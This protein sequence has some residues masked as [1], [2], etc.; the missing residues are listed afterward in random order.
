MRTAAHRLLVALLLALIGVG[1]LAGG[2]G[3]RAQDDP[4][5]GAGDGSL[6]LGFPFPVGETWGFLGP[7][8]T[9]VPTTGVSRPAVGY[10]LPKESGYAYT[11]IPGGS[12]RAMRGAPS[13]CLAP[14]W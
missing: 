1:Y 13:R 3:T 9:R 10:F 2:P 5:G 14:T 7:S 6:Q 4:V 8:Y 11:A 12:V